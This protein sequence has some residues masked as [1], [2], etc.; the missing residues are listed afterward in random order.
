M[1]GPAEIGLGYDAFK[2]FGVAVNP[3]QERPVSFVGQQGRNPACRGDAVAAVPAIPH[4]KPVTHDIAVD[5]PRTYPSFRLLEG[6]TAAGQFIARFG[7]HDL[8][9]TRSGAALAKA[10]RG[11]GR[12]GDGF[13]HELVLQQSPR[14]P[15]WARGT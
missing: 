12:N 10:S 8:L 15:L 5:G 2:R 14:H 7:V 13:G 11:I 4:A 6:G 3:V 1:S 9:E